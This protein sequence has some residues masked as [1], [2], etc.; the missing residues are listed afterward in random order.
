MESCGVRGLKYPS[1][2]PG[3]RNSPRKLTSYVRRRFGSDAYHQVS[4]SQYRYPMEMER[5]TD[6]PVYAGSSVM[7]AGWNAP[8][9]SAVLL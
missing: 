9:S 6:I 3:V 8:F 5:A 4:W 2:P 7:L 1:F